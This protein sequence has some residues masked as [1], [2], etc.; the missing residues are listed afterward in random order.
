MLL[1][2]GRAGF[3]QIGDDK[4]TNQAASK[5]TIWFVYDG[6]CPVCSMA[7]AAFQVRASVGTF[8]LVNAREET[9]HPLLVEVNAARLDLG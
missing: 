8:N 7:A 1:R 5:Q 2:S 9:R 4:V 6:E 3:P